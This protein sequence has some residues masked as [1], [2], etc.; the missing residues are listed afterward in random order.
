MLAAI[1][2]FTNSNCKKDPVAPIDDVKPGRRDYVWTVDTIDIKSIYTFS[3]V[4]MWGSSASDVW[5]T[6]ETSDPANALWHYDGIRWQRFKNKKNV[7]PTALFGFNKSDIWLAS[8]YNSIWHYN[9]SDWSEVYKFNLT[10]DSIFTINTFYG[11]YPNSL[12][13]VGGIGKL[14]ANGAKT[15]V[16]FY[17]GHTWEFI[18]TVKEHGLFLSIFYYNISQVYFLDG[19][20]LNTESGYINYF[21]N[22]YRGTT[23]QRFYLDSLSEVY[24]QNI[25]NEVYFLVGKKCYKYLN[26]TLSLWKDFSDT[27]F[28]GGI[29]GRSEKD[30]FSL[31]ANGIMHY[32]GENIVTLFETQ[33]LVNSTVVFEKEVFFQATDNKKNIQ[34]VL[35]GTLKT[36]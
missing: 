4:R 22:K 26:D 25:N 7:F 33:L 21:L 20:Y 28:V 35:H 6:G 36:N 13:A 31:G 14:G 5:L 23:F 3:L 24:L 17:D 8:E 27:K 1:L 18:P 34:L 12:F 32:N 19:Y 16:A 11:R 29:F 15:A 9:G 10:G 30:F 2:L